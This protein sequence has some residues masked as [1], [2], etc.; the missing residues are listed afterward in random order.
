MK[1]N[2]QEEIDRLIDTHENSGK[3]ITVNGLKTFLLDSG[4]GEAVV[5]IHGVPT[6][7]YLY[8]KM[9]PLIAAK[10]YRGISIDLPGLGLSDRPE[11]FEYSF[12]NFADFLTDA[13]NQLEISKYHLVVHDIGG[14]IGF[15]LAAKN[16]E[17]VISLTLLNTMV[18]IRNYKKPL[19]MRPFEMKI[20]GE[21]ELKSITHTTWPV[22]FAKMGVS[23]SSIIPDEEIKA[24][25]NLLKREDKGTAFLKIMRNFEQT[26][27]FQN[28][29]NKGFKNV[30]YPIQAIW[31]KDDPALTIDKYAEDVLKLTDAKK[32]IP[33][34][35]KHFLQEEVPEEIVE[36]IIKLAK[37]AY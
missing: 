10:G 27:E 16:M 4:K 32:V 9:I 19:V 8:R 30:D 29:C 12:S 5:C 21:A 13:L 15:A 20:L 7:S 26:E 35:S 36:H 34:A 17:K 31:G 22:M 2:T 3:Y 37:I 23:H 6:S 14:P 18:D 24:Y 28:L 25:V 1:L 11:D 33:L